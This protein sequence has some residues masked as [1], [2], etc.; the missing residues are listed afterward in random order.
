MNKTRLQSNNI[1]KPEDPARAFLVPEGY[2]DA[3][4]DR[5]MLRIDATEKVAETLEKNTPKE[6]RV[7]PRRRTHLIAAAVVALLLAIPLLYKSSF[8]PIRD[9]QTTLSEDLS[10]PTPMTEEDLTNSL[11]DEWADDY[12]AQVAYS[13]G[14]F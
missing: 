13:D 3:L 6:R 2:F 7:T 11:I 1:S 4:P 9:Q 10:A 5:L 12:Y 8:T 14:A